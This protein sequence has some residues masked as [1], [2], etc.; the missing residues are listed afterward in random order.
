M[1]WHLVKHRNS[2]TFALPVRDAKFQVMHSEPYR[3]PNEYKMF[4]LL[5]NA[6]TGGFTPSHSSVLR[7]EAA[8]N[9]TL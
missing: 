1:S 3:V 5:L 6:L 9:R 2:F 7:V 4:H 8:G